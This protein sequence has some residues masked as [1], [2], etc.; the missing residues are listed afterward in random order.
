M[1]PLPFPPT[2]TPF[3]FSVSPTLL[4]DIYTEQWCDTPSPTPHPLPPPTSF[5]F[6]FVVAYLQWT[7][8]GSSEHDVYKETNYWHKCGTQCT[9]L[10]Q[11]R[12]LQW[13]KCKSTS[14]IRIHWGQYSLW[15][16]AEKAYRR[17]QLMFQNVVETCRSQHRC[18]RCAWHENWLH[19]LNLQL[20][21]ACFSYSV[22]YSLIWN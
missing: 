16:C 13:A 7:A 9:R 1:T 3:S 4:L 6:S 12:K 2:P 14:I 8:N 21:V 5:S 18:E 17:V 10:N 19:I 22:E 20:R 11:K 15:N